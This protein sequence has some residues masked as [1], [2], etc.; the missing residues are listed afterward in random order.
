MTDLQWMELYSSIVNAALQSTNPEAPVYQIDM[1]IPVTFDASEVFTNFEIVVPL[2]FPQETF[3]QFV[4]NTVD[5]DVSYTSMH[6]TGSGGSDSSVMEISGI[7]AVASPKDV[8]F[9]FYLLIHAPV[10]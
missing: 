3:V 10:F 2:K 6:V 5:S 8:T 1:F 4:E 7:N 9:H